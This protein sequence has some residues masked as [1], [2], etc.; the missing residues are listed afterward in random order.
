MLGWSIHVKHNDETVLYAESTDIGLD[1]SVRERAEEVLDSNYYEAWGYG[2]PNRYHI[3]NDQ[4]PV[5]ELYRHK[6]SPENCQPP[7][8]RE[9]F[10]LGPIPALPSDAILWVELW[11]QS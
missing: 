1:Q 8:L 5:V 2:Y 7:L 4:L 10:N 11:D 9:T 3:R 6:K